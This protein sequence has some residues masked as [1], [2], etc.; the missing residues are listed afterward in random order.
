MTAPTQQELLEQIKQNELRA[1]KERA[2][3]ARGRAEVQ[4][5][6]DEFVSRLHHAQREL[7]V[8]DQLGTIQK[9]KG[10]LRGQGSQGRTPA[11]V[12]EGLAQRLKDFLE[13]MEPS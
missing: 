4:R 1:S 11:A 9:L 7:F 12:A 10:D 5:T 3:F 6:R 8:L 13:K 2:D